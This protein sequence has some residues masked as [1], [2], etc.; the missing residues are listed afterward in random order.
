MCMDDEGGLHSVLFFGSSEADVVPQ[1]IDL[2]ASSSGDF[3]SIA[4]S[5]ATGCD[6]D[7]RDGLG[8]RRCV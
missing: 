3:C 2:R 8:E 5:G 1:F 4:I 7:W 6:S